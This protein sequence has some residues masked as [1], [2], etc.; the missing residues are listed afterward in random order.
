V[1]ITASCGHTLPP[2][3]GLGV[4]VVVKDHDREGNRAVRSGSYC[5]K[6]RTTVLAT[7]EVLH[8]WEMENAWLRGDW[9]YVK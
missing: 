7:E 3:E 5:L 1:S 8:T 4:I 2:E 6:C 9:G